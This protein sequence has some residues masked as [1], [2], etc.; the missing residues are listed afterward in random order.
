MKK[1]LTIIS[2]TALTAAA[3]IAVI[4]L[5]A[6]ASASA[7]DST[8]TESTAQDQGLLNDEAI[9]TLTSIADDVIDKLVSEGVITEQQ[10]AEARAAV[11]DGRAQLDATDWDMV[12][13]Q[14]DLG[15]ARF[16]REIANADWDAI[17]QQI[18]DA[19]AQLDESELSD[20]QEFNFDLGSIDWSELESGFDEFKGEVEKFDLDEMKDELDKHL[21]DVDWDELSSDIRDGLEQFDFDAFKDRVDQLKKQFDGMDWED[22]A[23]QFEG[24]F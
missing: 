16:K 14:L 18:E 17:R 6:G 1:I 7:Q 22:L 2:G 5:T 10:A 3:V 20:L 23:K 13:K 9:G 24:Q 15:I 12:E 8:P 21:G 19:L 4:A 11:K